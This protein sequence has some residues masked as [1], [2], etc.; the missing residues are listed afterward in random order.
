LQRRVDWYEFTDVSKVF[1]ATII[2]EMKLPGEIAVSPLM[3]DEVRAHITSVDSHHSTRCYNP[4]DSS[5][6]SS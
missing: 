2:K 6:P 3:I 5:L 1:T 4:E